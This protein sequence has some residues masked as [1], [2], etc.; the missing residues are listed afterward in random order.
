MKIGVLKE[1][2]TK[3]VIHNYLIYNQMISFVSN[4]IIIYFPIQKLANIL[5]SR[6]S[7]VT[8]PV[9]SPK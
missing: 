3:K 5:P 1:N 2:K 8:C 7:V 6:S 4:K 9:I